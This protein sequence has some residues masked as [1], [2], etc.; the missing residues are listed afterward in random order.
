MRHPKILAWVLGAMSAGGALFASAP[1][2][3]RLIQDTGYS[4]PEAEVAFQAAHQSRTIEAFEDF[5]W[6]Y[7]KSHPS[8]KLRAIFELA[9]FECVASPGAGRGAGC[10]SDGTA[11]VGHDHSGRAG[12]AG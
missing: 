5:L 4:P 10:A 7:G 12:Y 1:A 8:L 2:Q 3:A 6:R 11:N 9:K